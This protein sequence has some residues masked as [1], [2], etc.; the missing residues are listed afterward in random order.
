MNIKHGSSFRNFEELV[1]SVEIVGGELGDINHSREFPPK[2]VDAGYHILCQDLVKYFTNGQFNFPLPFSIVVDKDQSKL[3]KRALIALRV[4]NLDPEDKDKLVSTIYLGHPAS[5]DQTGLGLARTIKKTLESVGISQAHMG[6]C[7][8]GVC[9]DGGII[10]TNISDHLLGLF[11]NTS[12]DNLPDSVLDKAV[13]VWDGAHIIELILEHALTGDRF[14]SLKMSKD[15]L[16]SLSKYFRDPTNYEVLRAL[17]VEALQELINSSRSTDEN[18][19]K[20]R[21]F[22][23]R[24]KE[25]SLIV[26]LLFLGALTRILK[27]FSTEFQI[28]GLLLND[29]VNLSRQLEIA[30]RKIKLSPP[31]P[32]TE[33]FFG[34]YFEAVNGPLLVDP[35]ARST[36]GNPTIGWD[37]VSMRR[38]EILEKVNLHEEFLLQLTINLK[39]YWFSHSY[40]QRRPDNVIAV[41][42]IAYLF[43]RVAEALSLPKTDPVQ[44]SHTRCGGCNEYVK[45]K[46]TR[47]PCDAPQRDVPS[48]T[49]EFKRTTAID[50]E[51]GWNRLSA[52]VEGQI[53]EAAISQLCNAVYVNTDV[54][55]EWGAPNTLEGH[56]KYLLCNAPTTVRPAVLQLLL[57]GLGVACS[58]AIAETYGS[59]MEAYHSSRYLNSGPANDDVRL[60]KEMFVRING[61][62]L[63]S[64]QSFRE[65]ISSKLG[66]VGPTQAYQLLPALQRKVKVSKVVKR[67]QNV[68]G[69]FFK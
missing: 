30:L 50:G 31:N 69:G 45:A 67:L 26:D 22:L 14:K 16:S 15:F 46:D 64:C 59:V 51:A 42:N 66:H 32:A 23:T 54:A 24:L 44:P 34:E 21:G 27:R 17:Y 6:R 43:N 33:Y 63:G 41:K 35:L 20:A 40:W 4:L 5:V 13:W 68:K 47:H 25:D 1:L 9:A 65:R 56:I 2:V 28:S 55:K 7:F 52:L 10:N 48:L 49:A 11:W 57:V 37:I 61:P 53:D 19:E 8:R 38:D 36:R 39:E 12:T 60:Q 3:R 62:P 29:Y 58:E 18:K